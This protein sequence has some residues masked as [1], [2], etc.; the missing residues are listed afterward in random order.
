MKSR[1]E[2]AAGPEEPQLTKNGYAI[3]FASFN[4][5]SVRH[6]RSGVNSW[7]M[8]QKKWLPGQPIG[9]EFWGYMSV[10][11]RGCFGDSVLDEA[12]MA[13]SFTSTYNEMIRESR[14]IW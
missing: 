6:G 9:H 3:I 8:D 2:G 12:H 14:I 4:T 13:K 11:L 1:A 10:M 7:G 5:F